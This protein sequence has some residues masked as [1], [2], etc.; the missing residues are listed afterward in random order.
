[1][2]VDRE[3]VERRLLKLE[4]TLRKLKKLSEISWDEFPA[5]AI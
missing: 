4:Q 5:G 1:L 2:V 3:T